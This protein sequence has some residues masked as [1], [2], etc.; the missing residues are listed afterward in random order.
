MAVKLGLNYE[1][2]ADITVAAKSIDG[3]SVATSNPQM[4]TVYAAPVVDS[5][6]ANVS[7]PDQGIEDTPFF[8][9]LNVTQADTGEFK[10]ICRGF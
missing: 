7:S 10:S 9:K 5:V 6:F 2:N 8:V 4:I 1:G 3:T